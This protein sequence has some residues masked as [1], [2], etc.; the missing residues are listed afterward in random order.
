MITSKNF[1]FNSVANFFVSTE[2]IATI[3]PNALVGSHA[4][5]FL[6]DFIWFFSI[7][8]PQGLECFTITVP[9]VFLKVCKIES[10]E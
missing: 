1:L 4:N 8:T 9:S 7:E 2:L 10:A 5:A 3:P 6:N